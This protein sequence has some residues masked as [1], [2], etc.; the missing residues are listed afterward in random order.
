MSGNTVN[1]LPIQSND[2]NYIEV[3]NIVPPSAEICRSI[4]IDL[5]ASAKSKLNNF[6][7]DLD[8]KAN[9]NN[10][11]CAGTESGITQSMVGY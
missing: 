5:S 6:Q 8:S 7:T 9:L 1:I 2:I 4:G 11:A 3:V 10:P